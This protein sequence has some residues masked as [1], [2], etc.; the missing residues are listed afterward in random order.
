MIIIF[1]V[2]II[3]SLYIGMYTDRRNTFR[4]CHSSNRFSSSSMTDRRYSRT[5]PA[6]ARG[7]AS[8]ILEKHGA[9]VRSGRR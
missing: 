4:S 7:A 3:V 2:I 9:R 6:A 8:W 5:R 1:F